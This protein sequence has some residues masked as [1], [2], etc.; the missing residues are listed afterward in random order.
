MKTKK[1]HLQILEKVF[2]AEINDRLPFQ[3]KA[4]VMAEMETL[5]LVEP[6]QRVLGGRF[7]VHLSGWALTHAGRI[8]YC[9][10][11]K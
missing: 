7:P 11:C 4:K 10:T 3:K 1:A 8:A 6:M 5:G 9:E 2:E